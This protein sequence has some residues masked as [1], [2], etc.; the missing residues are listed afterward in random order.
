VMP[1][2]PVALRPATV[3]HR[4][5]RLLVAAGKRSRLLFADLKRILRLERLR[6]RGSCGAKDEFFLT[7]TAQNLR[8][9]A[10]LRPGSAQLGVR[11]ALGKAGTRPPLKMRLTRPIS[12]NRQVFQRYP[13]EAV[14]RRGG[15][16][17]FLAS[18]RDIVG[19]HG[20]CAFS[21]SPDQII[22]DGSDF[23]V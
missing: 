1:V 3:R 13:P 21:E 8:R 14:V 11:T 5:T 23:P 6:L 7:A 15:R 9:L 22:Y 17:V 4:N 19:R 20:R 12:L 16:L 18:L 10:R 2:A